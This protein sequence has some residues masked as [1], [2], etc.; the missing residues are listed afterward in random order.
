M[1]LMSDI[2]NKIFHHAQAKTPDAK[3][4]TAP[5]P[6]DIESVLGDLAKKHTETL[7]WRTSIVD[8]LK[9]LGL[10]S[11]LSARQKLAD[12]LHYTGDK[13]NSAEMNVW[14]IRQV[15]AKMAASGGKIPEEFK[16]AG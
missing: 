3:P 15:M 4:A 13:S 10:D 8:L 6:V 11:S 16:K 7:N 9:L 14:L 2:V 5:A 1:S 12:E